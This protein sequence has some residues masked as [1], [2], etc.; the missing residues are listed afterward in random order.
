[1]KLARCLAA[2]ALVLAV[3]LTGEALAQTKQEVVRLNYSGSVY[4]VTSVVGVEKGFFREE[5]L[6]VTATPESSGLVGAQAL[7]GGPPISPW[8]PT[9]GRCSSPPRI[10]P[11]GWWP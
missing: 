7:G 2:G 6:A 4:A 3:G 5:G 10:F 1:M 11:S 8:G 9:S